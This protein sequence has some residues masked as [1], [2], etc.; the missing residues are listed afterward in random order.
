MSLQ[1]SIAEDVP[2]PTVDEHGEHG[3]SRHKD[4]IPS[5]T[6]GTMTRLDIMKTWI[7][8]CD[9]HHDS[10]CRISKADANIWPIWIIDVVDEC[11]VEGDIADRYLTLSYVWGG[12]QTL[13]ATTS[14]IERLKQ[15]GSLASDQLVLPKTIRQAL[16]I[17][18][19][20]GERYIWI[21]QL[22][23]LQD[24]YEHKQTQIEHMAEI[25]AN[26]YLTLLAVTG[27]TADHGL[28]HD[29]NQTMNQTSFNLDWR[30]V[31]SEAQNYIQ[32][33]STWTRR[34]W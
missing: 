9:E 34:G 27:D 33:S 21:D 20:L 10:C 11:I 32:Y 1:G 31:L 16:E 23:I 29:I 14:N 7:K 25:Y 13:Q 15:P 3:R 19:L 22:S 17:T 2:D 6:H 24:D 28:V 30:S 5:F 8:A 4:D 12:V 26:S 18:R